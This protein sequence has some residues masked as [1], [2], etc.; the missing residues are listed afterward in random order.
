M[1]FPRLNAFS[2]WMFLCSGILL[3]ASVLFGQAPDAGWFAY[4]PL[5]SRRYDPGLNMDFY[6]VALVAL[7]ISTT[8]GAVNFIVTILKHRAPGM[9]LAACPCF[10][11][12]PERRPFCRCWRSP[13]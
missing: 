13:R 7:T 11:T 3:Y 1:A 5:A 2:Y 8:V 4:V 12:A 10:C 6:P 9:T